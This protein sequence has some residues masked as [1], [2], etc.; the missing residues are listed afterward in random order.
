MSLLDYS[1]VQNKELLQL[2]GDL[3]TGWRRREKTYCFSERAKVESD[4]GKW[5]SATV[6]LFPRP[7]VISRIHAQPPLPD[8]WSTERDGMS[9]TITRDRIVVL[10]P[11]RAGVKPLSRDTDW[12]KT[13]SGKPKLHLRLEGIPPK[14]GSDWRPGAEG[15]INYFELQLLLVIEPLDRA[16]P[17]VRHFFG[18]FFSGGLPSLG[19]RA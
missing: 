2:A 16:P 17:V 19:K 15:W 10:V 3:S 12:K 6:S 13:P 1:F 5:L 18:P 4:Q 7:S 8:M 14:Y 9:F 11:W